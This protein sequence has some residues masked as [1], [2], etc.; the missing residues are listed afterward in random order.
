MH[1]SVNPWVFDNIENVVF[2]IIVA[3]NIEN[4]QSDDSI[5]NELMKVED[6]YLDF[7]KDKNL[8]EIP[9]IKIYRD[10]LVSVSIN[11]NKYTN[12]VEAMCKRISKGNRL[13]RINAL[14]DICNTISLEEIISLG[15][16][17]LADIKEDLIV[18]KS[19]EGD[20]YLAFGE[21]EYEFVEK[22]E[23]VFTS[24]HNIQTRQ[25]LWRQSE[26]GKMTI[27]TKDVFFQIVGFKGEQYFRFEQT[28]EKLER[29]LTTIFGAR[30]QKH[31]VDKENNK[32]EFS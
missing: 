10:A 9:A 23:L 27:D 12:S 5:S 22:G 21:K 29:A 31:I 16:H 32:I 28:L 7:F 8:K 26:I 3:H 1:Y 2:G 11:P 19:I 14:V 24:G 6:Y 4:A 18:R 20:K 30:I 25:W 17:D 13:P 15:G